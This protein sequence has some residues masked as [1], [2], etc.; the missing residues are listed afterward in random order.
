MKHIVA[1]DSETGRTSANVRV[2]ERTLREVYLAPFEALVKAGAWAVMAAYNGVDGHTMTESPILREIVKD[3]WGFD[4]VVVSDWFATRSTVASARAGLDLAMPGPASPWGDALVAAVRAGDVDEATVD[5]KVRRVLRLA[6]RVGALDG[7]RGAADA[8]AWREDAVAAAVRSA[9]S[10]GMV[11]V[12]NDNGLLPL[13]AGALQRVAVLGPNAAVARTLGG[14]S[15]TVFPPYTVSPLDGLSAALGDG[16][17]VEHAIG[18]RASERIGPAGDDLVVDPATGT[19][20]L[21]VALIGD[22]GSVLATEHRASGRFLLLGASPVG[23]V[24]AVEMRARLRA[25]ADGSYAVGC[26]GVGR[27]R[28]DVDGSTIFDDDVALPD[29]A[30]IVE[31]MMRPPQRIETVALRAGDEI[32]VVLRHTPDPDAPG[33]FFQ[34][35]AEPPAGTPGEE[36]ERAVALAAAADVAV[37]VVGTTDEVE[38][39]GFDRD[40]LAL[41]GEQDELV[42]RVA[43]ANPRT[44]VVVNAGAPVLLPW[45]DDV[46]A[47][48]LCWFPGQEFGNALADVLLGAVEPGGRL[49]TSWPALEGGPSVTPVDGVLDYAEG[50][51][52]GYRGYAK[53]QREPRFWFGHGLGYT[54]WE[55]VAAAG[56]DSDTRGW[57]IDVVKFAYVAKVQVRLRN[58]GSRPGREV[59]QVYASRSESAVERPARWLAG[60]AAVTAGPGE[61]V[62][63]DVPVTA[64]ALSYWDVDAH[65]WALEPGRFTLTIG[66]SAGDAALSLEVHTP[67]PQ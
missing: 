33:I 34:L 12:R 48:L 36:L 63:A 18:V 43:A 29:G 17:T 15:A 5:D 44:V 28:L 22:D 3:E 20:G 40:E 67:R 37:V 59:V 62:T 65:A 35:N 56:P 19:Q 30:D 16:V 49:P 6:A 31:A 64:R 11:L 2:D 9:A 26:S 4:G 1:N 50:L 24:A 55:Y 23:P 51:H 53:D 58:T 54:T 10:A 41:P 61:E 25:V 14:G 32:D 21:E 39:E 52:I 57:T 45:A 27:F 47:V 46:P 13:T 7:V 66:R 38:S 42:R 8:P 60:F